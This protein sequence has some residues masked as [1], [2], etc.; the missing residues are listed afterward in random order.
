[1]PVMSGI[2]VAVEPTRQGN[3]AKIVLLMVQAA[4]VRILT[5]AL[6]SDALM[7]E[8][9]KNGSFV[10]IIENDWEHILSFELCQARG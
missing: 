3:K 5:S 1:M 8:A 6:F 7:A 2:E 4:V 9:S 10:I